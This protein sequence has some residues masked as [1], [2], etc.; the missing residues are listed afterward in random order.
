MTW[1]RAMFWEG[2]AGGSVIDRMERKTLGLGNQSR[3]SQ[4]RHLVSRVLNSQN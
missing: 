2:Q 3:P 1:L 4:G